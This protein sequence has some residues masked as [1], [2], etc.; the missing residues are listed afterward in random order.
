MRL[1]LHDNAVGHNGADE[2]AVSEHDTLGVASRA[3]GVHDDG[4]ILG[5]R[6]Y[7]CSCNTVVTK[8]LTHT[9]YLPVAGN[10][11]TLHNE[12]IV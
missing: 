3:A 1:D 10:E 7:V 11:L 8:L 2:V 6:L 5:A 4:N 12:C 9:H